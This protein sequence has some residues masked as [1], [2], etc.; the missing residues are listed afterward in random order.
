M[1][2]PSIKHP[3]LLLICLAFAMVAFISSCR[4]ADE[5]DTFMEVRIDESWLEYDSLRVE[6]RDGDGKLIKT[7]FHGPVESV[8]D[9]KKLPAQEYDGGKIHVVITGFKN[10]EAVKIEDRVYDG[11]S[12]KNDTV[13]LVKDPDAPVPGDTTQTEIAA[14]SALSISACD[15]VP[16]FNPAIK[17]YACKASIG[18]GTTT[19]KA[20]ANAGRTLKLNGKELASDKDSDPM[21]L[22]LGVTVLLIEVAAEKMASSTY[23]VGV[24]RLDAAQNNALVGL[25]VSSGVLEPAFSPDTLK[26][27]VIL[28]LTESQ[29]G[30]SADV[31]ES[32]A[33][34]KINGIIVE[35][36]AS[37]I[38]ALPAGQSQVP[39]KVEV[40]AENGQIRNY[41]INVL[42]L[43]DD[44]ALDTLELS[45]TTTPAFHPDSLS[46]Q[47][48]VGETITEATVFVNP[49]TMEKSLKNRIVISVSPRDSSATI[50]VKGAVVSPGESSAPID[51]QMGL[52]KIEIELTAANGTAKR[53]YTLNL[54]RIDDIPPSKP[55]VT[56]PSVTNIARP[57]WSWTSG[58]GGNGT[59]RYKLNDSVLVTGAT[60][61]TAKEFSPTKDLPDSVHTLY[62]QERDSVGNWSATGLA[63]VAVILGPV[64]WY[65]F[66][67]NGLDAG[68][69]AN[70]LT[71]SGATFVA[72]R[73]GT[74]SRALNFDGI[75]DSARTL[76]KAAFPTGK[77]LTVSLWVKL[78]ESPTGLRYFIR[79]PG[80]GIF[81]D[82]A[83]VGMAISVP[84][85][86]SAKAA[87]STTSWVHFAGTYD[88][89]TIRAYLNGVLQSSTPHT[90]TLTGDLSNITLGFLGGSYWKGA[91]DEVRFYNRTLNATAVKEIYDTTKPIIF[92]PINPKIETTPLQPVLSP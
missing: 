33:E 28:P 81:M 86:N 80:I 67:G 20:K 5:G 56:A 57:I 4:V 23:E 16:A 24:V 46:Y 3:I 71:I 52:N 26:Y 10:G 68:I 59:F 87:V 17:S 78:P 51:L 76:G 7:L 58:G 66:D 73:W 84:T 90:G 72:D 30:V 36:G 64:S 40:K 37:H 15:L 11:K 62:V 89:I 43:S 44:A 25:Q 39:I 92:I 12:G 88:G 63:S 38:V 32:S 60:E 49:G 35:S 42:R 74:A 50:T 41:D 22:T 45:E 9:L 79:T 34:L 19:V 70:H 13:V 6:L 75:N 54:T 69:N 21:P 29:I 85:T 27:S 91:I 47:V 14:L 1:S 61:T 31:A 2:F 8:D 55:V 83:S 77:N 82:G 18:A 53:T 65:K 48:E